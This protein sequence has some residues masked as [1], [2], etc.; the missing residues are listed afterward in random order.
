MGKLRRPIAARELFKMTDENIERAF[1]KFDYKQYNDLNFTYIFTKAFYTHISKMYLTSKKRMADFGELYKNIK[2]CLH[3][4]YVHNTEKLTDDYLSDVL[5][6]FDNDF[7]LLESVPVVD[8][9]DGYE[10][11]HH[12]INCF[13]LLLQIFENKSEKPVRKDLFEDSISYFRDMTDEVII[14]LSKNMK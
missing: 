11:R 10:L 6:V 9:D 7:E 14:Y 5:N 12:I 4:Y 1:K 3:D 2:V 8:L 13:D